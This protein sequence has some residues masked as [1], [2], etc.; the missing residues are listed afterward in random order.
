MMHLDQSCGRLGMAKVKFHESCPF[1]ELT[2][3]NASWLMAVFGA[4]MSKKCEFKCADLALALLFFDGVI[5]SDEMLLAIK[6]LLFGKIFFDS[7]SYFVD[8]SSQEIGI[9]RVILSNYTIFILH[10][11]VL[12]GFD[13][14]NLGLQLNEELQSLVQEHRIQ[15]DTKKKPVEVLCEAAFDFF[16][17]QLSGPVRE[18]MSGAI[19]SRTLRPEAV[20]RHKFNLVERMT[21]APHQMRRP[22]LV[23][24]DHYIRD[25][26]NLAVDNT[27]FKGS[28]TL[29][30]KHL[31][32]LTLV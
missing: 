20:A 23:L 31:K 16:A 13:S 24:D 3:F 15:L 14:E 32:V 18:W 26:I 11:I 6:E 8:V 4:W 25:V 28:Q 7:E 27:G 1:H 22:R 17:M 29:R 30:L 19:K 12:R 5:N 2:I 10:Q 21:F 9:R